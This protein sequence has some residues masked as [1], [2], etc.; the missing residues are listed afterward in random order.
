MR[1]FMLAPENDGRLV[2]TNLIV[3]QE[4]ID[5]LEELDPVGTPNSTAEELLVPSDAAVMSYRKYLQ[6]WRD[7]G[8]YIDT[9]TIRKERHN[10]AFAIPSP[11]RRKSKG[12]VLH[13]VPLLPPTKKG[14][15]KRKAA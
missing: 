14:K 10:R 6:A 3:A 11:G 15:K 13:S 9:D 4:D 1:N 7:K 2:K 8:W 12:W 5:I